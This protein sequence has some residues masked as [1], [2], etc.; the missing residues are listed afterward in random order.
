MRE[1][2]SK[3]SILKIMV[4]NELRKL[5]IAVPPPQECIQGFQSAQTSESD[6]QSNAVGLL[7]D[8]QT[9]GR[10][11]LH[12]DTSTTPRIPSCLLY[13]LEIVHYLLR[14]F[15]IAAKL[16]QCLSLPCLPAS[17]DSAA[18]RG[19]AGRDVLAGP[20]RLIRTAPPMRRTTHPRCHRLVRPQ[21]RA[22]PSTS[23]PR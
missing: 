2:T 1:T 11:Y 19:R 4:S 7:S 18:A 15:Q 17:L 5:G 6:M 13:Q 21:V 14:T 3:V 9:S 22:C 20:I 10:V 12:I 16:K 23:D 8:M